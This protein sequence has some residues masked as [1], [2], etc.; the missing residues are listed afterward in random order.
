MSFAEEMGYDGYDIDSVLQEY[1]DRIDALKKEKDRRLLGLPPT[2]M[3]WTMKDGNEIL[4]AV[5]TEQHIKNSIKL[6]EKLIKE[7][8]NEDI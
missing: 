2:D 6:F 1:Q 4:M 8:K 5:M 7:Y 3:T